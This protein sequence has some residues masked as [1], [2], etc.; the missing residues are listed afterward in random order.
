VIDFLLE[1]PYEAAVVF[2][3]FEHER[4]QRAALRDLSTGLI[5]AITNRSCLPPNLLFR[6]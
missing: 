1:K 5:Q 6:G 2:V 4:G 3:T